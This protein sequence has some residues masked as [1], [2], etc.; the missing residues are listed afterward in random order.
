MYRL[1]FLD[2]GHGSGTPGKRTPVISELGRSVRENEFNSA[3]V[4]LIKPHLERS[5]L[6]PIYVA[7][8]D[9]DTPLKTRTNLA[10]NKYREYQNK[11]GSSKVEAVYVSVHYDAVSSE[12]HTAEGMTVFVY[13]DTK[14]SNAYKLAEALS[15]E[16]KKS[17]NKQ[18]FRGIKAENF[19]V[20]RETTM[21]AVLTENG[22]MSNKVEARYMLNKDYQ[23]E[24]AEH[25]ARGI[26]KYFGVKFVEEKNA[27]T[28]TK[29]ST[30]T[31]TSKTSNYKISKGDTFSKIAKE[32]GVSV[33]EIESLN[34]GVEPT[35]LQIGQTIKV[36]QKKK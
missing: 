16:L 25:H 29:T 32:Y 31:S 30:K 26:C 8:T 33:K 11:Y 2:D 27:G 13:K 5:G 7:P 19:H 14:A 17:L 35:K 28:A 18:K 36:P 15:G 3:V 9:D 23:K 24:V 4:K 34:K 6:I 10:N 12:W 22:F 1:V 20:L 21:P